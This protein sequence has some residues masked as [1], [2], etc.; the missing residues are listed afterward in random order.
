MSRRRL[1]R[2]LGW[3][4]A[5]KA[6]ALALLWLLFFSGAHRLRVDAAAAARQLAVPAPAPAVAEAPR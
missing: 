5:A 4:L 3:F 6:A 2:E 1:G